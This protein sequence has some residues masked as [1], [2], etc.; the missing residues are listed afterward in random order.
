MYYVYIPLLDEIHPCTSFLR[1]T[2]VVQI[3]SATARLLAPGAVLGF[4]SK[5]RSTSPIL[6]VV[7]P[8]SCRRPGAALPPISLSLD[9]KS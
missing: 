7:P 6:G 3:R 4:G 5:R 1:A 9:H 2:Y 8:T